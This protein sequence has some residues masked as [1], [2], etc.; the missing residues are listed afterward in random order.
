MSE[1]KAAASAKRKLK[2]EI[3]FAQF[4]ELSLKSEDLDQILTEACRLA[5]EVLGTDLAKVVQLQDDGQTMIVR[6]GVG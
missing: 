3:G 1:A 4:G 5:G 2:R 6:A